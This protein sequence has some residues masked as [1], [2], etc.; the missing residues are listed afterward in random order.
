MSSVVET[1]MLFCILLKT[2]EHWHDDTFIEI[3]ILSYDRDSF[4]WSQDFETKKK[5]ECYIF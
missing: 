1:S 2:F 5:I 4:S 3:Y